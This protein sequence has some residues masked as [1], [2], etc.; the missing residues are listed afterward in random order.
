MD[1]RFDVNLSLVETSAGER[2]PLTRSERRAL[3]LLAENP[4]RVVTREQILDAV[5]EPGSDKSDRNVDFLIN[6]LRRKLND[7]AR[8]PRFIATRYG[9]GYVWIADTPMSL[10]DIAEADA[11]VGPVLGLELIGERQSAEETSR[12][13]YQALRGAFGDDAKVVYAPNCPPSENF[14]AKAPLHAAEL[15]FFSDRGQT[16]CVVAIKEFRSGRVL[17]ARRLGLTE[18]RTGRVSLS[19]L[20]ED[21][22]HALWRS[23]LS[24]PPPGKPMPVALYTAGAGDSIPDP[25]GPSESNRTLLSKHR[26]E[27]A[28]KLTR[29]KTSDR[30]LRDLLARSPDDPE[31]KLLTALNT[32]SK[33]VTLGAKLFAKGID[34]R[35]EDEDEIEQFVTEALPH[36]QRNPEFAIIA[37]K[38]LHF[39]RRGYDDLAHDLCE[40]SYAESVYVGNSL[41]IVG[42]MRSF[43]GET[44]AAIHCL[45]QAL[46]LAS[47]G[48]HSHL[49]ALIIKCQALAAAGRWDAL[50]SARRELAGVSSI[51]GF[52]LEP[53]FG[54]P[55][56]PSLRARAMVFLISRRRAR[57]I[58]LHNHYVSGRLFRDPA[59]GE[60]AM[61]SVV[62]VVTDRFGPDIVPDEIRAAYPGLI[63]R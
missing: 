28:N 30:R 25:G 12:D 54:D 40:R 9:E 4:H 7:D 26:Q 50:E 60:N 35:E 43:F 53:L 48:S 63:P 2:V 37:G 61:R 62:R 5:S 17:V 44:D 24:D 33:Y 55:E 15:S 46:N 52:V 11:V 21:I 59:Y 42:Q 36:A 18:L 49:Y 23:R 38:L 14:G 16:D 13:I 19:Q 51:A 29:W 56:S 34:T 22:A 6:R 1:L 3:H 57:A 58:L 39:L 27:E 32:Q 31:L 45:D 47:P 10:H 8:A 20:R 41:S